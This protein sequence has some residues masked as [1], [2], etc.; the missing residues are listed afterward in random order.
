MAALFRRGHCRCFQ[1]VPG[2][3]RPLCGDFPRIVTGALAG[4]AHRHESA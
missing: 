1:N 2:I 3:G 4:R